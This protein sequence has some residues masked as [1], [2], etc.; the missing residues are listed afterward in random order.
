MKFK[1]T[2]FFYLTI[3]FSV[4]AHL[5]SVK[6]FAQ[7]TRVKQ[8]SITK[9]VKPKFITLEAARGAIAQGEKDPNI[10]TENAPNDLSQTARRPAAKGGL[11]TRRGGGDCKVIF[12]NHTD[13]RINLYVNGVYRGTA[14]SYG[15]ARLYIAPNPETVVYARA[16][17]ADGTFLFWGPESYDCGANQFVYFK[18][19]KKN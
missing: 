19:N 1:I 18:L 6:V 12:G 2:A 5:Q 8:S 11:K 17:F 13:F 15:D 9:P 14:D 10:K 7:K 4:F 3:A 16:D